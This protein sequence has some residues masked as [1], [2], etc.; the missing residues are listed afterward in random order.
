MSK[1]AHGSDRLREMLAKAK[2]DWSWDAE[3]FGHESR[4]AQFAKGYMCA[5]EDAVGVLEGKGDNADTE[6]HTVQGGEDGE[7]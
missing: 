2:V 5:M 3:K 1:T 6:V 7:V 4:Y